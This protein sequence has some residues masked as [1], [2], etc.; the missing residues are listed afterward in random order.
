MKAQREKELIHFGDLRESFTKEM[1]TGQ[2][3]KDEW[4][5]NRQD[6]EKGLP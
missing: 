5:F 6:K 1:T 4:N 2:C 3:L